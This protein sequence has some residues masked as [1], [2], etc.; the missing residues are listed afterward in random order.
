VVTALSDDPEPFMD[1]R[2]T[3]C[4]TPMD[5][6]EEIRHGLGEIPQRLLL[7]RLGPRRQPRTLFPGLGQLPGL[8][9]ITRRIRPPRPPMQVLLT[10]EIPYISGVRAV[11]QQRRLLS[12]R[13]LKP[14]SHAS[15]LTTTTDIPRRERRL[16]PSRKA[17]VSTPRSR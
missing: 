3:P 5:P 7:H 13:G 6:R 2:L 11:L 15:T 9:G 4:W 8:L 10:R 12:G 1:A 14:K 16:D 17:G